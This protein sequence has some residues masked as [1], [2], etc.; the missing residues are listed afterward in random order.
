MGSPRSGAHRSELGG[1]LLSGSWVRLLIHQT[2]RTTTA[3]VLGHAA[4]KSAMVIP[5]APDM[6][7]DKK[8]FYLADIL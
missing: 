1:A 6:E 2:S 5:E 7:Q 8:G 4:T 3:L